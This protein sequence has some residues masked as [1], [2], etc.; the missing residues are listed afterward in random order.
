MDLSNK[1]DGLLYITYI[2][3]YITYYV[4]KIY[5]INNHVITMCITMDIINYHKITYIHLVKSDSYGNYQ[6]LP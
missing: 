5:N 6:I 2:Q 3:T 4:F 1:N